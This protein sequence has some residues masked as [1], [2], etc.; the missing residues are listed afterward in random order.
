[1]MYCAEVW[2]S[3]SGSKYE[4]A[5]VKIYNLNE[6]TLIKQDSVLGGSTVHPKHLDK[7]QLDNLNKYTV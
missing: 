6:L 4:N 1:M 3:V 7:L 2:L 5:C